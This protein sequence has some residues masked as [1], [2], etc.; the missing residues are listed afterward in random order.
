MNSLALRS[1]CRCCK[2]FNR[3]IQPAFSSR[4]RYES[5]NCVERLCYLNKIES[6]I[7]RKYKRFTGPV[8]SAEL[9][10]WDKRAP[11]DDGSNMFNLSHPFFFLCALQFHFR[12]DQSLCVELNSFPCMK[13]QATVSILFLDSFLGEPYAGIWAGYSSPGIRSYFRVPAYAAAVSPWILEPGNPF[14]LRG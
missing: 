3:H 1:L 6:S 2:L 11:R 5:E 13:P 9:L 8:E 7:L 14:E 12:K 4:G 10:V